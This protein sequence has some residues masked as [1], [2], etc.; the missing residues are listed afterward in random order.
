MELYSE[1]IV[2]YDVADNKNRKKLREGLLD[3]GLS[4]IQKSVF[5]GRVNKAERKAVTRLFQK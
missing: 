5:W 3:I 1:V 2:T 4:D